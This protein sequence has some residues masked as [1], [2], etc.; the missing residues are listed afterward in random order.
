M[1]FMGIQ[2]QEAIYAKWQKLVNC[3]K[4]ITDESLK[5]STAIVL[6]NAQSLVDHQAK[7]ANGRSLLCEQAGMNTAA[8]LG[9]AT[10][11]DSYANTT[12]DARVPSIV[13][14]MIR[15]IY[16]QLIAHKLVGVQPMQAPIGMAFA[17][18]AK[19][20][21]FGRGTAEP[22]TEIGYLFNDPAHTGAKQLVNKFTNDVI[23]D[24]AQDQGALD[25]DPFAAASSIPIPGGTSRSA[26]KNLAGDVEADTPAGDAYKYFFGNRQPA[27]IGDGADTSDAENWAVGRDM[28]EA[29]FEILKA[30]V[31]AKTR[32]LGVQITRETEEDMKAMQGLNAQQE[33]SDL[34]SYEIAQELDRQLLGEIVQSAV[35]AGNTTVWNPA[36]A[37]GR[38]QNERTGLK[39]KVTPLGTPV[40]PLVKIIAAVSSQLPFA[41][42][43]SKAEGFS[44]L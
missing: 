14:P 10:P 35:R 17:F 3:G 29:G 39:H 43:F 12:G 40:V 22:G 31:T 19:Y 27:A 36:V 33:I 9:P 13:I 16:P 15:R 20:G 28:P 38:N 5:L 44:L 23:D 21:R 32:K 25:M 18:R 8:A 7:T 11:A 34:L 24:K 26:F 6:E 1:N 30:T 42:S 4:D 37:D 2:N 41:I